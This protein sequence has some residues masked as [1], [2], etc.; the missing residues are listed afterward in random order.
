MPAAASLSPPFAACG[1]GSRIAATTR[2]TSALIKASA[3]GG[4]LP[5]WLQGS[6]ET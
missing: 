1:L 3:Q 4:V 2:A 5:W 6:S